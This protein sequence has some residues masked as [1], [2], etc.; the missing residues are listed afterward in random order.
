MTDG[1][2]YKFLDFPQLPPELEQ[3]CIEQTKNEDAWLFEINPKVEFT[4]QLNGVLTYLK[5]CIF[6]VYEA[7][8]LVKEWL[9]EKN[10]VSSD[11]QSV[12][13][14]RS[15]GGN[16]LLPHIDSPNYGN[17]GNSIGRE[18]KIVPPQRF[19]ARNYLL[20]ESGPI[21]HFYNTANINDVIES[22][23]FEKSQWHDLYVSQYHGVTNINSDRISLSISTYEM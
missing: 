12:G 8:D 21:T 7:P 17:N 3:L 20:T 5:Q 15:Y 6:E 19:T 4:T 11:K 1:K 16:V 18:S 23:C 10:I 14:Q 2:Y 22:C 13:V 9:I